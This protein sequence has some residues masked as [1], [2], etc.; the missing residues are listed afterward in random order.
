M[1]HKVRISAALA[2]VLLLAGSAAMADD[3]KSKVAAA[4]AGAKK[5]ICAPQ[6]GSRIAVKSRDCPPAGRF[7]SDADIKLTGA[8]TVGGA[9]RLMDSSVTVRP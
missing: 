4:N 2:V 3:A 7:Y 8:A 1:A 6:T 9:L 5:S